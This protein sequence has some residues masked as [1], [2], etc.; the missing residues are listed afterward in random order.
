MSD[1]NI[2]LAANGKPW[3]T[4]AHAQAELARQKLDPSVFGIIRHE[5]GFAIGNVKGL[6]SAALPP[7]ASGP[8]PP[9]AAKPMVRSDAPQFPEDSSSTGVLAATVSEDRYFFVKFQ[10]KSSEQDLDLI[11]LGI[12]NDVIMV[13]RGE[14]IILPESYLRVADAAIYRKWRQVPGQQRKVETVV[15]RFPYERLGPA[16]REEFV[17]MMMAGN[18]RRDQ[19]IARM[20]AV[21][22]G[23]AAAA[24]G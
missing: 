4:E 17:Q 10:E 7:A 19:D 9:P 24:A 2:I 5:D 15:K 1:S 20:E 16:S 21:S 23:A 22:Q 13:R 12:N 18:E 6:Q 8:I 11:P 14:R 3:K